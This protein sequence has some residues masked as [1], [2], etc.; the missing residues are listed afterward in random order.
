VEISKIVPSKFGDAD[1]KIRSSTDLGEVVRRVA[2]LGATYPELVLILE[3][4]ARQKNLPGTLVVDAVPSSNVEYL[5]AILGRDATKKADPEVKQAAA[6]PPPRGLRRLLGLGGRGAVETAAAGASSAD[7]TR[8]AE[9]PSGQG[10]KVEGGLTAATANPAG[11]NPLAA[12]PKKDEALER[13][14]G[15]KP[16]SPRPRL[17]DRLFRGSR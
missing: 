11:A 10:P 12:G 9:P 7:A 8:P 13:A 3:A 4:A 14:G 15:E 6:A 5:A 1:V 2:N 16:A 17:F